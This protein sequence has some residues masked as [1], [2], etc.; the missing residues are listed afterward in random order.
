MINALDNL[1]EQVASSIGDQ[2]EVRMRTAFERIRGESEKK[3][4]AEDD[5]WKYL[6]LP[7]L[8]ALQSYRRRKLIAYVRPPLV[9]VREGQSDDDLGNKYVYRR[10]DL[11]AFAEKFLIPALGDGKRNVVKMK[12][13]A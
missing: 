12:R 7:S 3:H 5:A 9:K 1:I 11:D 4:F 13:S 10:E 8:E 2:L 6:G